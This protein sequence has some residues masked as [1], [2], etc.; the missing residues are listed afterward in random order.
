MLLEYKGNENVRECIM[1][2]C[3]LILV[4][5]YKE[6]NWGKYSGKKKKKSMSGKVRRLEFSVCPGHRGLQKTA[7]DVIAKTS[8]SQFRKG[9]VC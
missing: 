6:A 2:K 8:K 4:L 1:R 9:I 3:C 5:K 7:P